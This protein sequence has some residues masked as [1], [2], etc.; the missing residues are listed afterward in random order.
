[1]TEHHTIK[2]SECSKPYCSTLP[3]SC[4]GIYAYQRMPMG[5]SEYQAI[6]QSYRNVILGNTPYRSKYVTIMDNLLLHSSK[7]GHLLYL[8]DLLKAVLK[9]GL[10]LSSKKY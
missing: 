1:M 8:E 6:W 9:N 2:L 4:S 3:Y 10:K 5:L 7:H